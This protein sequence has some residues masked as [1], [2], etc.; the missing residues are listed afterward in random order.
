MI[1]PKMR[2][3]ALTAAMLAGGTG[4]ALTGALP[5]S[6]SPCQVAPDPG[7]TVVSNGGFAGYV[8]LTGSAS[9]YR[10]VC[11]I[12]QY[13]YYTSQ[14]YQLGVKLQDTVDQQEPDS[15][16]W[17]TAEYATPGNLIFHGDWNGN[18]LPIDVNSADWFYVSQN[19]WGN[20]VWDG[21]PSAWHVR[22]F[23][24]A[25][26]SNYRYATYAW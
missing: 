9:K 18:P 20:D 11:W 16:G 25:N 21:P 14:D 24:I 3:L 1:K 13:H 8:P 10:E 5:A 22:F 12:V 6:A 17:I 26:S 2:A 23:I 19:L 7:W 4:I 15:S